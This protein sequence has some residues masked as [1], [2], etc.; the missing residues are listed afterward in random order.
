LEHLHQLR[1]FPGARPAPGLLAGDGGPG[2]LPASAPYR[3][4]SKTKVNL[5]AKTAPIDVGGYQ[6]VTDNYNGSYL[7]PVVEALP[8]DTVAARI[9]IASILDRSIPA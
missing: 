7:A 4:R 3:R 1:T 8:G 5:T 9:E 2:I 6:V